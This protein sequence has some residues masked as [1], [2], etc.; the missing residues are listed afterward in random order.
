MVGLTL[1]NVSSCSASVSEPNTSTM[2]ADTTG[3]MAMCRVSTYDVASAARIAAMNTPVGEDAEA[4]IGG[5]EDDQ[6]PDVERELEQWMELGS[7]GLV[8]RGHAQSLLREAAN[9]E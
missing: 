1:M 5:E 4:R 7:G 8:G 6:R 9:G 2:I 3:M